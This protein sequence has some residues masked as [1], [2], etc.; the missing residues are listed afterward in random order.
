MEITGVDLPR[1]AFSSAADAR[2]A[3]MELVATALKTA[4]PAAVSR[5]TADIRGND[6]TVS[7]R[8]RKHLSALVLS[9]VTAEIKRH[10]HAG[11]HRSGESCVFRK[12]G[13]RLLDPHQMR[14]LGAYLTGQ[15]PR[16]I[17]ADFGVQYSDQGFRDAVSGPVRVALRDAFFA[18]PYAKMSIPPPPEAT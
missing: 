7:V 3:Q 17:K 5:L 8:G 2:R 16:R 6:G 13:T 4:M 18:G 11:G 14:M 1:W 12:R 9:I 15:P 10:G